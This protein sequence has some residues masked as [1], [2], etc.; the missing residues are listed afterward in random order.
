MK[1]QYLLLNN[2]LQNEP[3]QAI[4]KTKSGIF[5][6]TK[7]ITLVFIKSD[8]KNLGNNSKATFYNA[9]GKRLAE[10]KIINGRCDIPIELVVPST[11]IYLTVN[12]IEN[13]SMINKYQCE[14]IPILDYNETFK[15]WIEIPANDISGY[16]NRIIA[17]EEK[18]NN[19]FTLI[20]EVINSKEIIDNLT[21]EIEELKSKVEL[22]ENNYDPT[23]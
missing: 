21:K 11:N 12:D 17:L 10:K 4:I 20:N 1:L 22:L 9:N 2:L 23:L 19:L 13:T 6:Q 8:G 5:N 7:D 14:P 3:K 16:R 15:N 18:T